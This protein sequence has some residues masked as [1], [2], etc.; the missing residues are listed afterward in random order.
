M[1][2]GREGCFTTKLPPGVGGI[3]TLSGGGLMC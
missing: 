2:D 1:E 3:T